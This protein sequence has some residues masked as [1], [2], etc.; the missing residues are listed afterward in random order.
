[1][2]SELFRDYENL[3]T[4]LLSEPSNRFLRS[5]IIGDNPTYPNCSEAFAKLAFV[6]N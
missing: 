1:V 2:L 4:P 5:V 3:Q 6:A